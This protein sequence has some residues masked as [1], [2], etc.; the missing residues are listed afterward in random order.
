MAPGWPGHRGEEA[1]QVSEDAEAQLL[2]LELSCEQVKAGQVEHSEGRAD[3]IV[4]LS[5]KAGHETTE[6]CS[7]AGGPT[8]L[9]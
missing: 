6:A 1:V 7:S 2:C 3:L 8:R 5:Q 4:V 9:P